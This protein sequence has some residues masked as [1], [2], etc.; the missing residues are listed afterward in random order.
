VVVE[1]T[2]MVRT[3]EAAQKDVAV[4]DVEHEA[5]SL[6][7]PGAIPAAMPIKPAECGCQEAILVEE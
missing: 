5:L 4:L 3:R 2:R 6:S 7:Y 1:D